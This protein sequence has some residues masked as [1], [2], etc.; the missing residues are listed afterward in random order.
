MFSEEMD[1]CYRLKKAGWS[2][3][4]IPQATAVHLWEAAATRGKERHSCSYI[5]AE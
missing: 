4:Y 3:N 1:L 5:A 2:V